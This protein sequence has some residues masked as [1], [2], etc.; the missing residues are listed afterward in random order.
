MSFRPYYHNCET[1]EKVTVPLSRYGFKDRFGLIT[2]KDGK[3]WFCETCKMR[4]ED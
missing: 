1:N 3:K 4:L 2:S